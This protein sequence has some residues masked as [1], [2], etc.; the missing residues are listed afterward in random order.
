M[1]SRLW[2]GLL[3]LAELA[4]TVPGG[5][6]ESATR[7]RIEFTGTVGCAEPEDFY[8]AIRARTTRVVWSDDSDVAY[9]LRVQVIENPPR[10]VGELR[11]G[12]RSGESD[13]RRVV[14]ETCAEVVDALGL[15]AALAID[16]LTQLTSQP[17]VRPPVTTH[18]NVAPPSD[19]P[20]IV[21]ES[22]R[23]TSDLTL[24]LGVVSMRLLRGRDSYGPMLLGR[25]TW[26]TPLLDPALEVA[27]VHFPK[28]FTTQGSEQEF[29]T[30]STLALLGLC[31]S[32][33]DI[34]RQ[35]LSLCPSV[36]LLAGRM[37]AD[38]AEVE[39]PRSVSRTLVHLGG[40]LRLSSAFLG[41]VGVEASMGGT[42]PLVTR[43]FTLGD[44]PE[45]VAESPPL[46]RFGRVA[47]FCRF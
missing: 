6:E 29:A 32:E 23:L 13:T 25:L 2:F 40:E 15:T 20:G 26:D 8:Q 3:I 19:R 22:S 36:V 28:S 16:P 11:L 35:W 45:V 7:V 41:P 18:V 30:A 39:I 12:G 43:R 46:G 27:I 10:V 4:R 14:G 44:P 31:P 17:I 9:T 33:W 24:G 21:V 1:S 37:S 42:F 34:Y 38:G 47:F 5:A